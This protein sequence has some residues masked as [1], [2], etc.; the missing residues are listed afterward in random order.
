MAPTTPI[1]PFRIPADLKTR[2]SAKAAGEGKTLTDVVLD[3][4]RGYV[5]GDQK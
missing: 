4:L 5:E 1:S 2:A 3:L